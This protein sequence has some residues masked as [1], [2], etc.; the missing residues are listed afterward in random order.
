[1][2]ILPNKVNALSEIDIFCSIDSEGGGNVLIGD[3][4]QRLSHPSFS[5]DISKTW[6]EPKT[7]L[8]YCKGQN[9]AP[10]TLSY[11]KSNKPLIPNMN[12]ESRRLYKFIPKGRD[13]LI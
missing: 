7:T 5:I 12:V 13:K 4:M 2:K 8:F 6:D 11:E 3:Y 1:M 9:Q 10:V